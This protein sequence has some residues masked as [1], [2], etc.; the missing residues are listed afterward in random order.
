[1]E[2]VESRVFKVPKGR[3]RKWAD[4]V[5]LPKDTD[6]SMTARAENSVSEEDDAADGESD[7]LDSSKYS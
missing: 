7:T 1:M 4:N 2:L 5:G 6:M 3:I